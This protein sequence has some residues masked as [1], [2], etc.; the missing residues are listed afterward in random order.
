M[1]HKHRLFVYL[2][3][4]VTLISLI[5]IS[6]TFSFWENLLSPSYLRSLLLSTGIWGYLI[7]ILLLVLANPLPIPSTPIVIAAGYVYGLVTGTLLSIFATIVGSVVSF[8][9]V[10]H[11][12]RTLL[13]EMVSEHQIVHFNHL[14]K[15][16]G[17]TLA[18][19]SY[20][21]PIFPSDAISALLGLTRTSIRTFIAIVTL[22]HIPRYLIINTLGSDL[23]TGL[24]LRTV[25][26]LIIAG[27]F[28]LI[29]LFREPI[30]HFLFKELKK[31]KKTEKTIEH[32]I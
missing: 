3:V 7:V 14:F 16:R 15:K 2:L 19:I 9:L 17:L 26:V 25:L 8:L 10:R 28:I 6:S 20:V 22:G 21:V 11:F 1:R 13:E 24:T 29:A 30:K 4:I 23:F 32:W 5:F 31:L 27:I 12:G 18:F